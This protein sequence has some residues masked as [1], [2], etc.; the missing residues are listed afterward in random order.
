MGGSWNISSRDINRYISRNMNNRGCNLAYNIDI[1]F[2][3]HG[4]VN[5]SFGGIIIDKK[6][7]GE[8]VSNHHQDEGK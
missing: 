3:F 8:I 2:R 5:S 7:G 6:G 4:K 1:S